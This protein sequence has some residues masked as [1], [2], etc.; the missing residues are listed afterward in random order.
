MSR[1]QRGKK[2]SDPAVQEKRRR[3]KRLHEITAADDI[4]Y[5]GPISYQGLQAL[6]WACIVASVL[7]LI[8]AIGGSRD[9]RLAADTRGL[10][11]V[12]T[13]LVPLPLPFLLIANYEDM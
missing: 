12:L 4:R 1:K 11:D 8:L 13:F 7:R 10:M 5:R 9:P 3:V 2:S 6:G